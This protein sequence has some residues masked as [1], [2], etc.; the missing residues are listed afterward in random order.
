MTLTST[1]LAFTINLNLVQIQDL[2]LQMPAE[3]KKFIYELLKSEFENKNVEWISK[4]LLNSLPEDDNI[5]DKEF[6]ESL[7]QL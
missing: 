6:Y 7:K 4:E 3:Q 5:S 2:V 1:P